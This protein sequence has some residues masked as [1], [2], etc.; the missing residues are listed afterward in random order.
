MR[1]F[2]SKESEI[3]A[4]AAFFR[5]CFRKELDGQYHQGCGVLSIMKIA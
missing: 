2:F 3:L 4:I 5:R 1:D